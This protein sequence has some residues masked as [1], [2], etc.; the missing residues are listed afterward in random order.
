[1]SDNQEQ[2]ISKISESFVINTTPIDLEKDLTD[3]LH[4]LRSKRDAVSLNHEDIK[5]ANDKYNK[6]IIFLSLFT[7]MFETIKSQYD[8]EKES[9]ESLYNFTVVTPIFLT[10]SVGI[11]TALLK[12]KKFP[13]KM[14]ELTKASEKCNYCITRIRELQQTLNF[15]DPEKTKNSYVKEVLNCYRDS[16]ATVETSLYPD[17]RQ[18]YY[19]KAQENL[20]KIG[21]DDEVFKISISA[22]DK[23]IKDKKQQVE[24]GIL[25]L[26]AIRQE[27]KDKEDIKIKNYLEGQEKKK[28]K[29]IQEANEKKE[30]DEAQKLIKKQEAEKNK[31]E[32]DAKKAI[33]NEEVQKTKDEIEA[34]KLLRQREIAEKKAAE[35]KTSS[36]GLSWI[37]LGG[38]PKKKKKRRDL[39]SQNVTM[40]IDDDVEYVEEYEEVE[41]EVS[42]DE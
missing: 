8:V 15:E 38:T 20:I 35:K 24:D 4:E 13:E 39:E 14:E 22:I 10:T 5:K 19:N 25:S 21:E 40:D 1:M 11:L 36:S 12:F 34:K 17:V 9:N 28:A 3:K 42:D 23:E 29:K 18:D 33:K 16:L 6:F 31:E 37:G 32:A 41:V 27:K 2:N 30:A 7:A 26:Q